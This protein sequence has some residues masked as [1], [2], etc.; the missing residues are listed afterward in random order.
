[1]GR[2]E[3]R[4]ASLVDIARDL[5]C[6][7]ASV[8]YRLA[9]ETPYPGALEDGHAA[10]LWLHGESAELGVDPARIA[11]GGESAGGGVAAAVALAARDRGQVPLIAQMLTYPMLDDRTATR[12]APPFAGDFVW[13]VEANHFGWSSLLGAAPGLDSAPPHA[14]P[15]RC[16]DLA[17]LPPTFIGVGAL[18]LFLDEDLDYARRLARAGVP[19]ETHVY[20]GAFHAFDAVQ[21]AAVSQAFRADWRRALRRAFSG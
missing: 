8:D 9:P 2:P 11:I 20:P 3:M 1:M 17:G 12:P 5:G 10:L 16:E 21:G 6:L 13:S 7:I 15:A 19:V 18:D 14:A 4:H